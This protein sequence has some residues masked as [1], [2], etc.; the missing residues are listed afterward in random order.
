L[1]K[2]LEFEDQIGEVS[3]DLE[4]VTV[5]VTERKLRAQWSPELAQD[6]AAFHN[7]DAEAEL[8]ALLSEQVAAEIDREILRDLRKGAAWNLRWDYN[9]W[10]RLASIWN[11]SIY[12]KRLEPN[13]DYSNQPIVSS[14][15][16]I[17]IER[18]S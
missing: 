2:E 13:F 18:W 9:G 10:K 1:Y 5:S 15:P 14:N 7:I 8:T 6:V 12:S 3:F 4:S 17:N 11:Y 16:Q